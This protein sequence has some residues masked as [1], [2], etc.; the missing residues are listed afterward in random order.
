MKLCVGGPY[1]GAYLCTD[2]F[3]AGSYIGSATYNMQRLCSSNIYRC[4]MQMV[5]VGMRLAGQNLCYHHVLKS[6]LDCL[7]LVDTLNLKSR[8]CQ[9]IVKLVGRQRGKHYKELLD[10]PYIFISICFIIL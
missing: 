2:N 10:N 6:A 9:Q 8:E 1:L 4:E 3:L 5:R 7:H